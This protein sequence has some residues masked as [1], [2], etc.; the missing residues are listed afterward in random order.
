MCFWHLELGLLGRKLLHEGP[1][2][3]K[4]SKAFD[5]LKPHCNHCNY[6]KDLQN[7]KCKIFFWQISF[8]K[9]A[10]FTAGAG[11]H[12]CF[13][14][15]S[16]VVFYKPSGW[17]VY[18]GHNQLQLVEVAKSLFGHQAL[19]DDVTHHHGFLQPVSMSLK[20][21]KGIYIDSFRYTCRTQKFERVC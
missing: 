21:S 3:L 8:A 10:V 11:L 16:E 20:F 15:F 13:S 4:P 2:G 9:P 5:M 7:L 17:E 14:S 18:G 6:L 19:F 12:S 1:L